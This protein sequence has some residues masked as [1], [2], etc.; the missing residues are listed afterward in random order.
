ML[1][2]A[3]SEATLLDELL[4]NHLDAPE[5]QPPGYGWAPLSD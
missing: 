3:A 1:F 4:A 5:R 2:D